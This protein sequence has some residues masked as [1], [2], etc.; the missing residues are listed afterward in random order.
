MDQ[1]LEAVRAWLIPLFRPYAALAY[2][3]IRKE[4]GFPPLPVPTGPSQSAPAPVAP[5]LDGTSDFVPLTS[6]IGHLALFN[7]HLQKS[8]R[9]VEWVYS[10]GASEGQGTKTTPIWAVN[11][12]VDGKF[13]GRGR[14]YNKKAAR[15]EAAKIGLKKL[16]IVVW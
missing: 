4:H 5:Q 2:E 9:V 1:G 6:T 14:G 7:Q 11:V 8:N 15:N 12:L 13:Y 3:I 16:G 10:D